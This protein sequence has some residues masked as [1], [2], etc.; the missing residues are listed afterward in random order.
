MLLSRFLNHCSIKPAHR[1]STSITGKHQS[2]VAI[3]TALLIVTI[4]A[5]VS[6]SIST[7]LQLDVRRTG[8]MIAQDQ[9]DFYLYAAEAW[10]QRILLQDKKDSSIDN[11]NEDWALELPPIPVT[12]GTI[13]GSLIDLNSRINVNSLLSDGKIN[14]TTEKRLTQLFTNLDLPV[15]SAQAI[16]DWIDSDLN[17]TSP[18]GAEDI[19][20]LNLDLPYRTANRDMQTVS[21]IRLIKGFENGNDYLRAQQYLCAVNSDVNM[22]INVNT[23]SAEVLKSLSPKMT[24]SLASEIIDLRNSKPFNTLNEFTSFSGLD[25]IITDKDGLDVSS[26]YF[27]LRTQAVIGQANKVMYSIIY[28]DESGKTEIISRS[29]RTL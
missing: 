3:I 8:N 24:D 20:Y 13:Q 27:L 7:R 16:T 18:D 5:T 10:T 17:T 19:H 12:G 2:G 9:A 1:C 15:K 29:F 25:T 23:A 26:N 6:M 21:E 4:A 28:R 22:S 14:T 11:Y